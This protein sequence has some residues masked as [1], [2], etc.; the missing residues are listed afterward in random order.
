MTWIEDLMK[1]H[2]GEDGVLDVDGFKKAVGKA[3]AENVV[4]KADYDIKVTALKTANETIKELKESNGDNSAL[5]TKV[6]EYETQIKTLQDELSETKLTGA[7][8]RALLGAKARNVKAARAL[9][10]LEKVELLE[11]GS[12]KGM[13]DQL[14]ALKDSEESGFLFEA[15]DSRT[16]GAGAAKGLK[17]KP[18]AGEAHKES[19]GAQMAAEQKAAAE[20]TPAQ[21]LWGEV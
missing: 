16:G 3:Y 15:A 17:Y 4:E 2:T 19:Y 11:D 14:K 10:D 13:D 18:K 6:G 9:L 5:Q 8:E 21:S 1:E 12:L 20:D 7:V